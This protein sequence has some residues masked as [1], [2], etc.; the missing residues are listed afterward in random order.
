MATIL[1]SAA[2]AAVGGSIGGTFA[3][4]S[5]AVIGRAVGATLGRVIDQRLLGQGS[6]AVEH[7]RV[8]RFRLAN[9]GEGA[10]IGQVYG[11]M[12]VAGQVIWASDFKERVSVSGGGGKGAPPRPKTREY[13]YS[14]SLAVALCEGEIAGVGRIWADGQE[15]AANDIAMRVY[16]GTR[17]QLADPTMEAVEGAGQVPAY[18]GT[19]YVV[20]EDLD[21]SAFGNRVP[22]LSFEVLRPEQA[23]AP[24]AGIDPSLGLRGVAL[25]PGSGEYALATSPVHYT[26]GRTGRW[27][28]NVH[29]PLGKTDFSASI[30]SLVDVA[31]GL[32]AASL[33][34]SWFGDDLRCGSCRLRPK[35]ERKDAEGAK[36]PWRV[37]GVT[38]QMAEMLPQVDGRPVYGGTP[39]DASVLQAIG[40]LKMAG[41]AVM[42][43]PFVLMEQI[44]GN[45]LPDPYADAGDQPV[46]PW[47]GRITLSKAPGMSGSPDGTA[48]AEMEVAAFFGT[49]KAADF[50]IGSSGVAY[51]GPEEWSFSRFIL[52]YA[53]LCAQ[54]G[55]VDAFCIGSELRG[56]TWIRG[57][58]AKFPAVEAMQALAAEVRALLG[59][60]TK[61]GYAADWSEYFGYQPQDGSGDRYFHLD[62]LWAD[63]NIDFIGIDNYMPLSDWRDG[64]AHLDAQNWNSIYDVDYLAANIAGGEG[65]DWYYHSVQAREAQIRTP[66]TDDAYDE[67]WV[68]RYKDLRNWWSNTHHERIG[69]VRQTEP[70]AW[71]PGSKPF[72]FTEMGCAAVDKGTN[73]PNK[74]LDPKSSETALPHFSNGARDDLIQKQYLSAVLAFWSLPENN[75]TSEI[76]AGP[77]VNMSRAFAWAWDTR[78]YPFFPNDTALWADGDNYARGH[79]LNGRLATRTLASVVGEIC[80]RAGLS[81]YD[82]KGLSGIVRGFMIDDVVDARSALQPLMLRYGFDAIERDGILQF[83]M[84]DRWRIADLS[85]DDLAI[86]DE[87][88]GRL[89]QGREA[90]AAMTGRIR[91]RFTEADGDFATLSEEAILSDEATHSVSSTELPLMMTRAEGRQLAERWLTEARVARETVRFALPPSRLGLGAGDLVKLAIEDEGGAGLFRIDRVEQGAMQTIEAVR[92]EPSVYVPA[93]MHEQMPRVAPFLPPVPVTSLFLDLPLVSGDEIPHAPHFAA[94][95]TPWPGGVALYQSGG[96]ED[97]RLNEIITARSVIGMT[98]TVLPAAPA[99]RF[100]NG[101]ALQIRLAS[102]T[103]QSVSEDSLLGGANLMAIGDGSAGR[104][105]LF[106]FETAELIDKDT[107]LVSRRLRGQAGTDAFADTDWPAGSWVVM[108]DGRPAQIDL[109]SNLRRVAQRFRIGP[110]NKAFDDPSYEERVEAFD[111]NGLRPYALVHLRARE[112]VDGAIQLSWIRRSRID[113]ERWDLTEVPLGEEREEYVVRVWHAGK[114]VRELTLSAPEWFYSAEAQA[115]DGVA[116]PFSM[117]VAQVSARFGPG[118]SRRVQI[119]P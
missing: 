110:A 114:A 72:W 119:N 104:W 1:L 85:A 65:F 106:Q 38:R 40:A 16:R 3:G 23:S 31:S 78:P 33:V 15:I 92:V 6:D 5:T 43:Y 35:V 10:A 88:E 102:G 32:E 86:S 17:D 21:L 12:R 24:D 30:E 117:E 36:M 62:P 101:P 67:A 37:A 113:G 84:R 14:V 59:A 55:G 41:K 73:E 47:R 116:K 58:N 61:I 53:A 22:Q 18:R 48:A 70:T 34:V 93:V 89:E 81:A 39:T 11:R 90:E 68:W 79:W 96:E 26:D 71:V 77:M 109:P 107:Y 4:L 83:V 19:A 118:P 95:A 2:G 54:A 45:G 27:T 82:T 20:I 66:I 44:A 56:L 94:S 98:E 9:A 111:G 105:E 46:L 29:T 108:M 97:F 112:T 76:Y 60:E 115:N 28:A 63:E 103:L 51:S 52:H 8:D 50:S 42:F 49:A 25:V 69:G 99:G 91:V 80:R 75:P 64:N 87:I 57:E 7:G 100:E 13:S 74:F